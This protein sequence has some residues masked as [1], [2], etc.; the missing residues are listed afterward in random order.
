MTRSSPTRTCRYLSGAAIAPL[1]FLS[2]C[3]RPPAETPKR[4][5]V[6]ILIV[7]THEADPAWPAVLAGA[8]RFAQDMSTLEVQPRL[9]TTETP[10]AQK[11]LLET[12]GLGATLN[13]V[14]VLTHD[15]RVIVQPLRQFVSQ[16]LPVVLIG[17]DAPASGRNALIGADDRAVG[18][19]IA[20]TLATACTE[21]RT[22]MVIHD[23]RSSDRI[24]RR[25]EGFERELNR[26]QNI[27]VL[28]Q[29]DC[30]G[31]A[32]RA[33]DL[34]RRTSERY[35]DLGGWALLDDWLGEAGAPGQRLVSGQAKIVSYGIH[36]DNLKRLEA[37]QVYALV[38]VN[39]EIMGFQAV[40]L[41][42][43]LVNRSSLPVADTLAPPRV[44][45]RNDMAEL[46]RAWPHVTASATSQAA[47]APAP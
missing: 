39:W 32:S 47:P 20:R 8:R 27:K 25:E 14:C 7:G 41:C 6:R 29:F 9:P 33:I 17:D 24:L 46:R 35:P 28:R 21:H 23:K 36:P 42:V 10:L 16:G 13:A 18:T 26:H 11:A 38:D 43:Q 45:T 34:L 22:L 30:L 37:G 1:L 5:T 40:Q 4:I 2:A 44:V 12:P 15:A 31:D 3:D 19:L